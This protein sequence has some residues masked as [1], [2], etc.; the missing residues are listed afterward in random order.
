MGLRSPGAHD[1]SQ[2]RVDPVHLGTAVMGATVGISSRGFKFTRTRRP[3]NSFIFCKA[4]G[5]AGL[6]L[7]STSLPDSCAALGAIDATGF[8]RER[9]P[10]SLH[11]R[12][13]VVF[14]MSQP[15]TG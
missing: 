1:A 2:L 7:G 6:V 5:V 14:C 12:V 13:A 10:G 4:P 15:P 11:T 9:L 3:D 8:G